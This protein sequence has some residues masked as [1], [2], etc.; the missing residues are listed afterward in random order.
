MPQGIIPKLTSGGL[1]ALAHTI[2]SQTKKEAKS[3]L[4]FGAKEG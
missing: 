4:D 3:P 2:Q 1:K